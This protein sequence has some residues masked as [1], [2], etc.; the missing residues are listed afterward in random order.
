MTIKYGGVIVIMKKRI[1][2]I[3]FMLVL[4][5]FVF[6][7]CNKSEQY[8]LEEINLGFQK[9]EFNWQYNFKTTD[10]EIVKRADAICN[11]EIYVESVFQEPYICNIEQIDW[12]VV[13][14]ESP[15]TFMLYLQALNPVS[16]L[17]QAYYITDDDK[18]LDIA[19]EIIEQWIQYKEK[20]ES[21]DNPYLWYDHGTAIR[22]NNL[23][24]F[25]F[26]YTEI[27]GGGN[28][29]FYNRVMN[30][31]NEH[32]EHLSNEEE[33]FKNHNH[34]IFQ[35][36]ALIY[37]AYFLDNECSDD[38]LSLAKT[39]VEEQKEYAF[40]KEM[41]HVEN[42]PAYQQGVTELF[43]QIAEFLKS[44][45][46]DFGIQLYA[47]ISK[48][49]EFMAW[50]IKPNGVLAEIGDTSSIE[51]EKKTDYG[52]N[53]YGNNHLIYAA[54]LG[55]EG[56][57]PN[58]LSV[59]YPE[60]GYYFGRNSWEEIDYSAAT[61]T[62][63]KAGYISKTHKHADDLSFMLYSKGYDILVDSGWYNYMSGNKYRDYFV[64]A[65]AHNTVIV[66]GRSYSPTV[67]NNYK[68]G[69]FSYSV[70]DNW[71]EVIAYN[72]MYEGV[73][74]DR[75]FYYG[76]DVIVLVDN[77]KSDIKHEYSQL[78]QL[79]EYMTIENSDD[80]ELVAAIG[81]SG[82]KLRI[83]QFGQIPSL[84]VINGNG[85]SAEYGYL[86]R[87]MNKVQDINTLKY[88]IIG[89]NVTLVTVLSI[90]DAEGNVQVGKK[91]ALCDYSRI[92]Y[93][94]SEQSIEFESNDGN[95][96]CEWEERQRPTF[97]NIEI[98]VH[99]DEITLLNNIDNSEKWSYAWYLTDMES[100]NVLEKSSYS[101]SN[102]IN[103]KIEKDGIYIIKAY[104]RVNKGNERTSEV[105]AVIRKKDNMIMDITEEFPY[106][107]LEYLGHNVE[108]IKDDTYKFSVYY[109][110]FWNTS[111]A[112]Y[113]Y[114]DGG[115]Y[116]YEQTNNVNFIEYHF[117]EPGSYT[118]MYYL[119]T[120][121]GDNEFW[122]FEEIVID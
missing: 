39:R 89:D 114:K 51:G 102:E 80:K 119:R 101:E 65:K 38:W 77:I 118:V 66:D 56:E 40:S 7:S 100:A 52:M 37:L 30:I 76:G 105:V 44:Q 19:R 55:N 47:D 64:S 36:Q 109:N 122:N 87:V 85:G 120:P 57:K 29:E 22:S 71:D 8:V 70:G 18:Y 74:I 34:G 104:M 68:T 45:G 82:Y 92:Y 26:A 33:Y 106:L 96:I 63:F 53:K 91:N 16:Y 15:G 93:N 60:S 94:V 69:I 24:Y 117:S 13:F 3:L 81:D 84:S 72:N 75:H 88:D 14:S 12:D 23:I 35:D 50:A 103:F 2:V 42:S 43:Y 5:S 90:E 54:T 83:R 111:I 20:V 108:K 86:S 11:G 113:I 4:S 78:F 6:I 48:S 62:M 98:E 28:K 25:L 58:E 21:A 110:Y 61:W 59:V 9:E 73:Q 95:L 32:G 49:L 107:N 1:Y 27:G 41:V 99:D 116:G 121:N 115:S 10:E 97:E 67:E 17:T 79:S 112:W 31:L 46:D